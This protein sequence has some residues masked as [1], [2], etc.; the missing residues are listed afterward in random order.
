MV[1][2]YDGSTPA[3]PREPTSSDNDGYINDV[4]AQEPLWAEGWGYGLFNYYATPGQYK[5]SKVRFR[6][7]NSAGAGPASEVYSY[8][9]DLTST[10][11]AISVNPAGGKWYSTPMNLEVGSNNATAIYYTMV[12]TYDG[13]IP[14]DPREPTSSSNDGTIAVSGGSGTFQLYATPGQY[15]RSK[16][17]FRGYNNGVAGPDSG[18]Y[19]YM[20]DFR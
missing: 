15:K 7:Y 16:L 14:A 5:R 8:T 12:N 11:Y 1:N 19:S 10:P 6:G 17:R 13:S 4:I 20:I 2:T 9:I 18:V 3:D